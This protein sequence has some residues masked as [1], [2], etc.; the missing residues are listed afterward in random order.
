[1]CTQVPSQNAALQLSKYILHPIKC[2]GKCSGRKKEG[3]YIPN[4][5]VLPHLLPPVPHDGLVLADAQLLA[6]Y[7]A[8]A[9][10]PGLVFVV[11]VLLQVLFAETGLLLVIWL[12]L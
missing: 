11:G 8:G 4:V 7:Q 2:H 9:L 6:I 1:M 5:E 3:R 10:R 12:F